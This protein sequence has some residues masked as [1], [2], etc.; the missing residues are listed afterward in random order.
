MDRYCANCIFGAPVD[1]GWR[2]KFHCWLCNITIINPF[3]KRGRIIGNSW[4]WKSSNMWENYDNAVMKN[5]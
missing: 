2:G 1:Y 3:T 4:G 5:E